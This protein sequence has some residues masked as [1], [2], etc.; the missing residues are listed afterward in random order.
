LDDTLD[1]FNIAAHEGAAVL[2]IAE[3]HDAVERLQQWQ[4]KARTL[5]EHM[6]VERLLLARQKLIDTL[7]QRL[8]NGTLDHATEADDHD[9]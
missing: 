3:H 6:Q 1:R 7:Q 8:L 2:T 5:R 9:A 4:K